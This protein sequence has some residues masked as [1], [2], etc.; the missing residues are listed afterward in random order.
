MSNE[1]RDSATD[2]DAVFIAMARAMAGEGTSTERE[3][4]GRELDADPRRAELFAA[5]DGALRPLSAAP[6]SAAVDT[7]AALARVLSRRDARPVLV[8]E[9]PARAPRV[10]PPSI[11]RPA[12]WRGA[13]LLRLAAAFVLLLG[14]A[15]VWRTLANRPAPGGTSSLVMSHS[16]GVGARRTINLPDGSVVQLAP[17]STIGITAAYGKSERAVRLQG[18]AYFD[19]RHDAAHPFVVLTPTAEVRDLGTT[20]S[21]TADGAEGSRVV[22]TSGTVSLRAQAGRETVVLRAGDRGSVG[23][24][25]EARAERG[26]GTEDDVAWTHGRLVFRDA[27]VPEVAAELQ[28]WYGITL[29]VRDPELARRHLTAS[30]GTETADEAVR[31]VAAALGGELQ[32]RGDTAAV[33]PPG[34]APP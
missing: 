13:G 33:V 6:P 20:F 30:F 8:A 16:T 14:G 9:S 19:V 31:V 11:A 10:T 32:R 22:V 21:V 18:Q 4:F 2:G 27:P 1:N 3:A 34:M 25:G 17:L 23:T 26:T 24:A 15:L 28:R 5:L 7:E 29:V 12:G